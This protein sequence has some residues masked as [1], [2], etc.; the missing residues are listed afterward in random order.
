MAKSLCFVFFSYSMFAVALWDKSNI[1]LHCSVFFIAASRTRV[2]WHIDGW[3]MHGLLMFIAINSNFFNFSTH[4]SHVVLEVPCRF[5][6]GDSLRLEGEVLR[7][8]LLIRDTS[9]LV[10]TKQWHPAHLRSF[11][12]QSLLNSWQCLTKLCLWWD[13]ER[14]LSDSF[15]ELKRFL[16]VFTWDLGCR[17]PV[18]SQ[19]PAPL[20]QGLWWW[21]SCTGRWLR[22]YLPSGGD[23][24]GDQPWEQERKPNG[25][26]PINF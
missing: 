3:T 14:L 21:E 8:G 6:C 5:L 19:I 23:T 17:G 11:L 24:C 20:W 9:R 7:E 4:L 26:I 16:T 2:P 13:F 22:F 18:G 15:T 1:A 25:R 10:L 12:S